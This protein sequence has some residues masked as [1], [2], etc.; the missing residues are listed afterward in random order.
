MSIVYCCVHCVSI[1]VLLEIKMRK[2]SLS[3]HACT[4]S[5]DTADYVLLI[6]GQIICYAY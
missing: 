2:N 1:V 5:L 3:E 6:F 4:P